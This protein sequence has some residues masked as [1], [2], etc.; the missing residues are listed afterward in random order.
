MGRREPV[1]SVGDLDVTRDFT[2][3]R[4]VINAYTLLLEYGR[5]G[6]IYNVCSGVERNL[7]TAVH[8][9]A[10]LAGVHVTLR[11]DPERFRKASQ[12]RAVGNADKIRHHTGWS[13]ITPW[14]QSLKDMIDHW[15]TSLR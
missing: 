5:P 14:H 6:E 10:E 7:R 12:Q 13:P 9:L 1:L 11:T 3:F 15:K 4:D 8:E 2:D